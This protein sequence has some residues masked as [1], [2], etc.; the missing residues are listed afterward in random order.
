VEEISN[1]FFEQMERAIALE[2]EHSTKQP[3]HEGWTM[4]IEISKTLN[5]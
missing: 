3:N 5:A 1:F 2:K 4:R